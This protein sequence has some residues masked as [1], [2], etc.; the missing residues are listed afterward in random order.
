MTPNKPA[1]SNPRLRSACMLEVIG[2]GSVNV[3]PL[4]AAR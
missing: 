2:A 3:R 1:A 4:R